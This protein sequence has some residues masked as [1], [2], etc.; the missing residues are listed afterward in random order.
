MKDNNVVV[1][2]AKNGAIELPVDASTETIWATQKQIAEVFNV[3]RTRVTR[4]IKNIFTDGE[5]Q[6]KSNVR[7]THFANSDKPVAIYSLDI[8][9]AVGYRT[10]SNRAIKF[11]KWATQTLRSYITDGYA[12]NPA[13]IEH[14]KSQFTKALNDL[15]LLSADVNKVGSSEV[16]DIALAFANTWFSLDAYD[17]SNLPTG[18]TL[19]KTIDISAK[20][21]QSALAN[22]KDQLIKSKEATELF[23]TERDKG[24][25]QSLYANVFQSFGGR[26]V[27]PTLEE[28]AAHLLYFTVK[29]HVFIDGNK[30]SGA[31]AFVWF[32]QKANLLNIHQISPQA[33]TAITLL[34][35]ESNPKNKDKMIGVI[36]LLLG[37]TSE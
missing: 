19:K 22:L 3:D 31:Y 4:H 16:T 24:G 12:I 10:N 32:L 25:L 21:L 13:R 9:L 7:K 2:Q 35:A 20:E 14:N 37:V 26:D 8:I 11:R 36:L 17:K 28:K 27:Y 18:G 6:Q 15:K 29:N 34:V 23:G 30:R 33:L 5:V 1:Y